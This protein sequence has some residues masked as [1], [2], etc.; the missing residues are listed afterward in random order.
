MYICRVGCTSD[1]ICTSVGLGVLLDIICTSVGLG[2]LLI[3]YV[4][5]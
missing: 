1:I 5:L 2:V 4:H 3:L